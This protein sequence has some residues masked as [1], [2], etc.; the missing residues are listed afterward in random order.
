MRLVLIDQPHPYNWCN[1]GSLEYS[2]KRGKPNP[3]IWG[4][5][6]SNYGAK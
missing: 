2:D 5:F 6:L 3:I 4:F 1:Y